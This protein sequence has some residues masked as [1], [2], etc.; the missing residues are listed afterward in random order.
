MPGMPPFV[1]K[2]LPRAQLH[3]DSRQ[4]PSPIRVPRLLDGLLGPWR[5]HGIG[6]N[7]PACSM[8]GLTMA[9]KNL[10]ECECKGERAAAEADAQRQ[11]RTRSGKGQRAFERGRPGCSGRTCARKAGTARS[12][13]LSARSGAMIIIR[14][15]SAR[16][17]ERVDAPDVYDCGLRA[18]RRRGGQDR[19]VPC[20]AA[21]VAKCAFC[22][23]C[24][25]AF[26]ISA[27]RGSRCT[28]NKKETIKAT[29]TTY[30][31]KKN[32]H[33]HCHDDDN[34]QHRTAK[35]H[36]RAG[37]EAAR[38]VGKSRGGRFGS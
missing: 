10:N 1:P 28:C 35:A 23:G 13:Y 12:P 9:T 25:C 18:G 37:G 3:L 4:R 27:R 36:T 17:N 31:K 38:S 24:V 8:G 19:R 34:H 5:H 15:R 11:R 6:I 33:Y 21:A 26:C 32:H 22:V 14:A 30:S 2:T 7:S 20:R 29:T 16:G